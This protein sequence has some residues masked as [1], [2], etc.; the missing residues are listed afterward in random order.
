[1][2][3]YLRLYLCFVRF[4]L[5]RA[6]EFRFDFFFRIAMDAIFYAVHLCFFGILF[7]HTESIAGWERDDIFVFV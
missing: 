3:R 6:F 2:R 7:G 5:G 1:M 4:A